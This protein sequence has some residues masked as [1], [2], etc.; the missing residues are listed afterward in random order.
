M[1]KI[2]AA[3]LVLAFSGLAQAEGYVGASVGSGRL[4]FDCASDAKCKQSVAILKLYAGTRLKPAHQID[5]GGLARLDAVEVGYVRNA[6]DARETRTVDQKYLFNDPVNGPTFLT[7]AVPSRRLVSMDAVL[8]TPV[9]RLGLQPDVDLFFK[10][11]AAV[12]TTTVESTLNDVRQKSESRTRVKPYVSLG[13]SIQALPNVKVLGSI[14]A[15]TYGVGEVSGTI[16]S[17]N[18]GAEMAF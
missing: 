15:F 13:A 18:L 14:D 17:F 3:S 11:G 16:S 9:L 6:S 7:R 12:V 4:P 2:F 1:N 5:L 8:L 10:A